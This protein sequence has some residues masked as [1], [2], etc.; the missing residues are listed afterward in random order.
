MVISVVGFLWAILLIT[1]DASRELRPEEVTRAAPWGR[2][3]GVQRKGVIGIN[4]NKQVCWEDRGW[5]LLGWEVA[6][7]PGSN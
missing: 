6:V 1:L 5:G 4:L 2:G 3:V 7:A